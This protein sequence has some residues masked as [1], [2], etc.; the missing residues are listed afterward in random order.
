VGWR[1]ARPCARVARMQGLDHVRGYVHEALPARV[2][3]G[4]GSVARVPDE[5]A[6]LGCRRVLVLA[7]GAAAGIGAAIAAA[8]GERGAGH[9]DRVAQ[10]VPTEVAAAAVAAASAAGADGLCSVGGGSATGLAKAVAVELDLP[11]LAV[12][13]TYAGSEATP[14]YGLTGAV[15][16]TARDRRALPRTIVYDPELTTGLPPRATAA[17]AFNALAHAVAALGAPAYDPVAGLHAEAAARLV[18][19]AL[20]AAV[21]RPG[22]LAARAAL[23]HAA[24]L[25]G[26]A[27]AAVATG[28]QHRLSHA[29]GGR[30]RLV[31]ADIHAVLLPYTVA[32]DE[33]LTAAARGRIAAALGADD[34]TAPLEMDDA[35]AALGA[36]DAAAHPGTPRAHASGGAAAAAL[37]RLARAVGLPDGLAAIGVPASVL[38]AVAADAAAALPQ[39]HPRAGDTAWLRSFL[40]TAHRGTGAAPGPGA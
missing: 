15:K 25:A 10:H 27:L 11:I 3:F 33:A 1:A 14:V 20:P 28:L 4:A 2:V 26:T 30:S 5:L 7:G 39:A 8:L 18:T 22:D 40:G 38:D 32:A 6:A 29:L 17:S 23:L 9:V 34:P 21:E 36:D 12:P 31:H 37:G 16:R 19:A 24:Y 35:A 13:T